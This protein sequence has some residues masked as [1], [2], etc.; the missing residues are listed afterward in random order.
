MFLSDVVAGDTI[1]PMYGVA[2]IREG[3]ILAAVV[4]NV[5]DT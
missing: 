1:L 4:Y 2:D 3:G 5:V